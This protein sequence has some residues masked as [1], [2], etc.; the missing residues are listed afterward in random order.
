M[1]FIALAAAGSGEAELKREELE[2][3]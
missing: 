1:E 3:E 2:M